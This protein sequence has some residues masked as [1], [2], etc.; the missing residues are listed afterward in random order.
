MIFL[1]FFWQW[2]IHCIC[3]IYTDITEKYKKQSLCSYNSESL[4]SVI[5]SCTICYGVEG[6]LMT[7]MNVPFL[8]AVSGSD[9][10]GTANQLNPSLQNSPCR[11]PRQDSHETDLK[12]YIPWHLPEQ[13]CC[14]TFG[15]FKCH[16]NNLY[17]ILS[18]ERILFKSTKT[19]YKH[20]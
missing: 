4:H 14:I 2:V 18:N 5:L 1:S 3:F 7:N 15:D 8:S 19:Q 16:D 10:S 12:I 9:N 13:E 11:A 17:T 6:N 20:V